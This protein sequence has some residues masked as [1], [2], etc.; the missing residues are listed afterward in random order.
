MLDKEKSS[1][2]KSSMS[3]LTGNSQKSEDLL[4]A[5]LKSLQGLCLTSRLLREY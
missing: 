1:M 3:K 5:V 4:A 2:S